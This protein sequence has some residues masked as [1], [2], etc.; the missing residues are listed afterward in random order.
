MSD[1]SMRISFHDFPFETFAAL[2]R[3]SWAGGRDRDWARRVRFG[4]EVTVIDQRHKH[5]VTA[6]QVY[7]LER[8]SVARTRS[9]EVFQNDRF[10]IIGNKTPVAG[11]ERNA[12]E[13]QIN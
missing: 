5:G 6:Y 7:P 12:A 2:A 9:C 3:W 13:S 11:L 1:E 10:A 8:F 4:R